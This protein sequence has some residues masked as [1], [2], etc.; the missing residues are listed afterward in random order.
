MTLTDTTDMTLTGTNRYYRY[1]TNRYYRYDTNRSI[2]MTLTGTTNPRQRGDE[3]NG[4]EKVL[5]IP[6]SS[7]TRASLSDGL[8]SHSG[9]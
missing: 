2:D 3:S 9:H 6:K 8:M 5:Y 7:W 4:N 1:D